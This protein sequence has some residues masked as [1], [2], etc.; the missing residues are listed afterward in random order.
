MWSLD[1]FCQ[2]NGLKNLTELY[3]L[4]TEGMSIR[5]VA[6]LIFS[7]VE[8]TYKKE[9]CPYTIDDAFDWIDDIGGIMA[10][11]KIIEHG[12]AAPETEKKAEGQEN[13]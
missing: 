6:D 12:T 10:A 4:I 3:R 13:P 11:I 8:Y 5:A 9:T 1:R 2:K 7:A